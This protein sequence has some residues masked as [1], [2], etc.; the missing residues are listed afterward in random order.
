MGRKKK[1][2]ADKNLTTRQ[3]QAVEL[4]MTG[5]KQ[6]EIAVQMGV[7]AQCVSQ[8]LRSK[9]VSAYI[10][11][12]TNKKLASARWTATN[13]L[14]ELLDDEN[15]W[16]RL[17]AIRIILD[18]NNQMDRIEDTTLV[19]KFAGMDAPSLPESS[20]VPADGSVE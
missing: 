7:T 1:D 5:L 16:V 9:T 12:V 18:Q 8:W 19:V 2:Q 11:E 3:L 17:Q 14:V 6:K 15:P 4:Y 13:K 20:E 10:R